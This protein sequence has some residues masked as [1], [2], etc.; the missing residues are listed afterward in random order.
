MLETSVEVGIDLFKD[1]IFDAWNTVSG[2]AKEKYAENDPLGLA[3][4]RYVTAL[5]ER[6]DNIKVLGMSK[7][8]FGKNTIRRQ[9]PHL[10]RR[11]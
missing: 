10:V 7:P 3:T 5:V 2:F 9:M 11:P 1:L 6:Y 4:R 8:I